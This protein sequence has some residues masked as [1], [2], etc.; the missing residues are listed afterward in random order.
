MK[1][2]RTAKM[3]AA[4]MAVLSAV[5]CASVISGCS[6]GGG[7]DGGWSDGARKPGTTKTYPLPGGAT[8]EMV[9]CPPGSFL[10]GSPESEGGRVPWEA[11]H[12]VTLTRGF[13]M[14]RTELTAGQWRSVTGEK[15]S[16]YKGD[17]LPAVGISQPMAK[18]FCERAGLQL[19]TEAQWEYACRAGST[20]PFA[21]T[22]KPDSMGWFKDNSG[23][24][25]HPVGQKKPNAWGLFDMHGNANEWCAGYFLMHYEKDSPVDPV[26]PADGFE[27]PIRGG[28]FGDGADCVRSASRGA[29]RATFTLDTYGF[30]PILVE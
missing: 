27:R 28:D 20:G 10:M 19:P 11:Q 1:N 17:D 8:I 25:L 5:A 16:H 21:G 26:G 6:G 15:P 13:W 9:W 2:G 30:R 7:G 23:G 3:V 12:P 29:S 22:G 24:A 14:A 4:A 18:Q